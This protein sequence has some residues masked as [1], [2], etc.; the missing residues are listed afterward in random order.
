MMLLDREDVIRLKLWEFPFH[1]VYEPG[2]PEAIEHANDPD[3]IADGPFVFVVNNEFAFAGQTADSLYPAANKRADE[4][5]R[6]RW[7][8]LADLYLEDLGITRMSMCKRIRSMQD[9]LKDLDREW[10]RWDWLYKW[11]E[12]SERIFSGLY[13]HP[14]IKTRVNEDGTKE[15]RYR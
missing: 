4:I 6:L 14:W 8:G 11:D 3:I 13:N 5:Q 10:V 12:G 1:R 7:V 15:A 9:T 2:T